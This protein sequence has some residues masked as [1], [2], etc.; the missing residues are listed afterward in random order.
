MDFLAKFV[1][2][3]KLDGRYLLDLSGSQKCGTGGPRL[4]VG[5]RW[6]KE[7]SWIRGCGL[8]KGRAPH[9]FAG[10]GPACVSGPCPEGKLGCGKA[11]EMRE[12]YGKNV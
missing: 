4:L 1:R 8:A 3:G 9:L 2:P 12:R 6:N 11:G 7:T 5:K 10:A